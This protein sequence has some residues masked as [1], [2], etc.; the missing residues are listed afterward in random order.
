MTLNKKSLPT[1]ILCLTLG[2]VIGSLS[3]EVLERILS[4][5]GIDFSL[6]VKEPLNL[7]DLYVLSVSFRVNPGTFLGGLGGLLLFT[8]I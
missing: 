5:L 6:T 4:Q 2:M 7:F 3:W 8:R 1:L